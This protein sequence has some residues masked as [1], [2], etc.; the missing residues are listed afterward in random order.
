[1]RY[2]ATDSDGHRVVHGQDVPFKGMH[3]TFL[4]ASRS[5]KVIMS[6]QVPAG[7]KRAG[8]HVSEYPASKFGFTVTEVR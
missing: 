7:R 5:G 8:Y 1:M 2:T 4:F 6:Y 3:Y